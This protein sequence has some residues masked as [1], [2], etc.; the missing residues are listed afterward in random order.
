M[1]SLTSIYSQA[2]SV[3]HIMYQKLRDGTGSSTV[4][5]HKKCQTQ[6]INAN[7]VRLKQNMPAQRLATLDLT[8]RRTPLPFVPRNSLFT[9]ITWPKCCEETRYN[10]RRHSASPRVRS[11]A[12]SRVVR[13]YTIARGCNVA[14]VLLCSQS[15]VLRSETP[16][17]DVN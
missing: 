5:S 15:P 8:L 11:S 4:V 17:H 9:T 3:I 16:T 14:Q 6:L 1:R 10:L 13:L 12:N 2:S 7:V